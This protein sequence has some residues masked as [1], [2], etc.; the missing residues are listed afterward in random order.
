M[1]NKRIALLF[2][3]LILAL[4]GAYFT[5]SSDIKGSLGSKKNISKTKTSSSTSSVL[6]TVSEISGSPKTV[7]YKADGDNSYTLGAWQ[8]T[9]ADNTS[10][11]S[12]LDC[13]RWGF[14]LNGA[15]FS[16]FS[17]YVV[18]IDGK[19]VTGFYSD[20]SINPKDWKGNYDSSFLLEITATP[21]ENFS[22]ED[23]S[24]YLTVLCVVD[25]KQDTTRFWGPSTTTDEKYFSLP[26]NSTV[27][28]VF[29]SYTASYYPEPLL[30]AYKESGTMKTHEGYTLIGAWAVN[31]G[32]K[33]EQCDPSTFS[34]LEP[35]KGGLISLNTVFTDVRLNITQG[36]IDLDQQISAGTY[37]APTSSDLSSFIVSDIRFIP[38]NS[39]QYYLYG[40]YNSDSTYKDYVYLTSACVEDTDN[41]EYTWSAN[42]SSAVEA[43]YPFSMESDG[44]GYGVSGGRKR[45]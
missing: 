36:D 14:D 19:E 33:A 39:Y 25:T 38:G 32:Q 4:T 2:L 10:L 16:D 34:I 26:K 11:D 17:N 43:L 6:L 41:D 42:D 45:E 21:I 27:D 12:R 8:M 20:G 15:S 29:G 13:Q 1:K 24:M 18:T 30:T 9:L 37:I 35:S 5:N 23:V 44:V 31:Y 40:I 28:G 3:L 22:A 7:T